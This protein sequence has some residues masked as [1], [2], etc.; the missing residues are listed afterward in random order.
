M[1]L[2][3][4]PPELDY[5][6]LNKLDANP[7]YCTQTVVGKGEVHDIEHIPNQELATVFND[8]DSVRNNLATVGNNLADLMRLSNDLMRCMNLAHLKRI[9]A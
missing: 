4:L 6:F 3:K 7:P 9:I 8:V 2:N 5:D 1:D